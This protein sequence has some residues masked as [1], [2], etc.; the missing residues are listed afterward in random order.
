V[1]GASPETHVGR[2]ASVI[3]T[4][5]FLLGV[6]PLVQ[7]RL[8]WGALAGVA[9]GLTYASTRRGEK[10]GMHLGALTC[11]LLGTLALLGSMRFWP[12]A[13][14]I[15]SAIYLVCA[16]RVAVFGGLP[17]WFER[18][19]LDGSIWLLIGASILIS[20]TALVL[21]FVLFKPDY[22]DVLRTIFPKLP[23]Y[24]LFAGIIMFAMLNAALEE[25]MYRGL[26]MGSLDATLGAGTGSVLLQ[27]AVFGLVHI[28]GFPRGAVGVVLATIYGLMMGAVRRRSAGMLAPWIAHVCTDVAIGSI[29]LSTFLKSGIVGRYSSISTPPVSCAG[30]RMVGSIR[31]TESVAECR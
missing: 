4:L 14:I 7:S 16:K 24:L 30:P 31:T 27:A 6:F 28:G 25:F 18:G 29:L 2:N 20:S 8:A 15:A 23:V 10:P 13:P 9:L 1:R 19:R 5:L 17:P 22:G 21:W 3:L 11:L 26:V 12:F